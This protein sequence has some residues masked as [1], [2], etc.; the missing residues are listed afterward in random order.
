MIK[1][2]YNPSMNPSVRHE[3]LEAM[4]GMDEADTMGDVVKLLM[5]ADTPEEAALL[6]YAYEFSILKEKVSARDYLGIANIVDSN[7]NTMVS[8]YGEEKRNLHEIYLGV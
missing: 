1:V 5:V 8:M 2:Q 6:R 4:E 7:I 3:V